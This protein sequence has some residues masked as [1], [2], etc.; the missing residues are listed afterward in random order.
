M[1]FDKFDKRTGRAIYLPPKRAMGGVM[2]CCRLTNGNMVTI[3]GSNTVVLNQASYSRTIQL[4]TRVNETNNTANVF[5][6][7]REQ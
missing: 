5:C 3:C 6:E 1:S 4:P 2:L 7:T